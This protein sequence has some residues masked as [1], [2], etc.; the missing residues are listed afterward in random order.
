VIP[1]VKGA[2][3]EEEQVE[4]RI[5][6]VDLGIASEHTVRAL[7]GDGTTIAKRKAVPTRESLEAIETAALAGV[8]DSVRLEVVM[9]PTGPAW[10]P[11]AVVFSSRG[12]R[13]FRVS[14]QKSADLRRFFRRHT[15]SNGI[16]ADALARL[17]IVAPEHLRPLEFASA[18]RA[19]L[20]RR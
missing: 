3:D 12:H 15:K 19:T 2:I 6:G 14:S 8:P 11:I 20:D 9:E 5:I 4:R 7:A 13:L 18:D 16:A 10:L 1:P 17:A